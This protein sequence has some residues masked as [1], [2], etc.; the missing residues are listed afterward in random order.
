MADLRLITALGDRT[1]A[2]GTPSIFL[3]GGIS[4]CPDWQQA[5]IQGIQTIVD[6]T[7]GV[8][9]GDYIIYNPRRDFFP[10]DNPTASEAQIKWEF[11]KLHAA[12]CIA[13]WFTPPT[14]NPIVFYEYG[15][16]LSYWI[17]AYRFYNACMSIKVNA[18][19]DSAHFET[20]FQH[21]CIIVGVDPDFARKADVLHQ[22]ALAT[23]GGKFVHQDFKAFVHTLSCHIINALQTQQSRTAKCES[24]AASASVSQ[25]IP[26]SI[27]LK[28]KQCGLALQFPAAELIKYIVDAI[29]RCYTGPMHEMLIKHSI[30][31]VGFNKMVTF[32]I[33][34]YPPFLKRNTDRVYVTL[35]FYVAEDSSANR[36]AVQL[37]Y[38]GINSVEIETSA[39][40]NEACE[41][42]LYS[43]L[44]RVIEY[45]KLRSVALPL[46]R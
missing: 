20:N 38:C 17:H 27:A 3:A 39:H 1:F 44:Q 37:R 2:P 10:I 40:F 22:T 6:A 16:W 12:G 23:G 5:C 21:K 29:Q 24:D 45:D 41:T 4:Q 28:T 8:T 7:L 13:F 33:K 31:Y 19:T 15:Y 35:K 32:R 18:E 30:H 43:E 9:L 34:A 46:V 42:R 36:T 25:E 26:S 11:E 14:Q